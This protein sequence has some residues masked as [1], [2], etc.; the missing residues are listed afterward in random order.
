MAF[1]KGLTVDQKDPTKAD[2]MNSAYGNDDALDDR[3][4][5]EHNEDGTHTGT[6]TSQIKAMEEELAFDATTPDYYTEVTRDVNDKI[7]TSHIYEDD[8]K[9]VTLWTVTVTRSA[10]QVSQIQVVRQSDS[11][12]ITYVVGRD[13]GKYKSITVTVS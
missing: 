8:T 9:A 13:A 6:S 4:D 5:V 10:G 2:D 7:E 11:T 1:Q 12:T 3:L